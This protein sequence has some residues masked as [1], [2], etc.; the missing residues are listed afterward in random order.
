MGKNKTQT[1]QT[2]LDLSIW[3]TMSKKCKTQREMKTL[4]E[5]IKRQKKAGVPSGGEFLDVPELGLT[6]VRK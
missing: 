5:R 3:T 4:W 1:S 6:L 2:I